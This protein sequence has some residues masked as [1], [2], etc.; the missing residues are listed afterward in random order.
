MEADQAKKAV[1]RRRRRGALFTKPDL[2]NHIGRKQG[3]GDPGVNSRSA[4]PSNGR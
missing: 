2:E 3:V 1:N 4:T